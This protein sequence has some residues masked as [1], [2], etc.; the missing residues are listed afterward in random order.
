VSGAIVGD[1]GQ[2]AVPVN[3]GDA[4]IRNNLINPD[5]GEFTVITFN[6]NISIKVN[7]TVYD[8]AGKP[9]DVLYNRKAPTG[10]NNVRWYGKNKRGRKVGPGIYYV[11]IMLGKERHVEKVLVVR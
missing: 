7:I 5:N 10:I 4:I 3:P 6:L 9:V 2:L 8:L 1:W 11:V